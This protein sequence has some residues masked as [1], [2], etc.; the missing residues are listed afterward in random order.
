VTNTT[1]D[2]AAQSA[3]TAGQRELDALAQAMTRDAPVSVRAAHNGVVESLNQLE[4]LAGAGLVGI[5]ALEAE[6]ADYEAKEL[7]EAARAAGQRATEARN[8]LAAAVQLHADQAQLTLGILEAEAKNHLL[9]KEGPD[10]GSTSLAR[11]EVEQLGAGLTGWRS[12]ST[13]WRPRSGNRSRLIRPSAQR[14]R[15]P[16]VHPPAGL[17]TQRLYRRQFPLFRESHGVA[18]SMSCRVFK[19]PHSW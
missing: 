16:G 18:T 14:R 13:S 5:G 1:I 6:V 15:A 11:T 10:S 19:Y 7:P 9:V 3:E 17:A 2:E 4:T 12:W 8:N